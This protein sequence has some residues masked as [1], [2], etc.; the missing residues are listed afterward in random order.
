M[1]Q[2]I[3]CHFSKLPLDIKKIIIEFRILFYAR[4]KLEECKSYYDLYEKI[5]NYYTD[6]FEK[7]EAFMYSKFSDIFII[8]SFNHVISYNDIINLYPNYIFT[9]KIFIE[10]KAKCHELRKNIK[11]ILNLEFLNSSGNLLFMFLYESDNINSIS[12]IIRLNEI[13]ISEIKELNNLLILIPK[14]S[15]LRLKNLQMFVEIIKTNNRNTGGFFPKKTIFTKI[16]HKNM[17]L[18]DKFLEL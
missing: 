4:E 5:Y 14:Y 1:F 12:D 10:D 18:I 16:I 7:T 6:L 2:D 17:G 8:E 13:L 3:T 9:N 11:T 15:K